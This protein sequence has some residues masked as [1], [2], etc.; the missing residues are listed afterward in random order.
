MNSRRALAG[1]L[2]ILPLAA[3]LLL[4]PV[5]P[6]P[7]RVPTHWSGRGPDG[8]STGAG[9]LTV[10][11]TTAVLAALAAAAAALLQRAIPQAWSRWMVAVTAAMG[12]GAVAVYLVTVWRVGLDGPDAVGD[13]WAIAGVL[14]G[15]L[16]GAVAYVVHGRVV[17]SVEEAVGLV[18]ERSRVRPVRGRAVRPVERWSTSIESRTMAGIGW[19]VLFIFLAISA[20]MIAS[21]DSVWLI[22]VMVVTGVLAGGLA[23]SWAAVVVTVDA[24]G[25]TIRSRILGLRIWRVLAG[26]V[27]GVTVAELDPMKWGGIG[28]RML[29]DRTAYIV[30]AGGV[31]MVIYKRDGR[32]FALQVTQGDA[33][34]RAGARTLLQAAG[35]RLGE[36]ASG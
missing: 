27:V 6:P 21:G 11:F 28:L 36:T 10:I 1:L 19:G 5:L 9:F 22:A 31:G 30:G 29:P 18:P 3:L 13:G 23:L 2:A 14:L 33:A 35:Q 8:W 7:E 16:G 12:W 15:L 25:L 32:R 26:Q 4:V 20:W 17:P 24:G 34:A